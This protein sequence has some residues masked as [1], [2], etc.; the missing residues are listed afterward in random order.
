MK[1]ENQAFVMSIFQSIGMNL[2]QALNDRVNRHFFISFVN[3]FA[4]YF[5]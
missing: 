4:A 3:E 1:T 5:S 2:R